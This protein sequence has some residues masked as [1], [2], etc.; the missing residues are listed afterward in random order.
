MSKYKRISPQYISCFFLKLI[1]RF[2]HNAFL[3]G[4]QEHVQELSSDIPALSP[5]F[6]ET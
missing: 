3:V 4:L 5:T 2:L 1:I 6:D